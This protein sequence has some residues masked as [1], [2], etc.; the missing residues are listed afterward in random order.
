MRLKKAFP[1][2]RKRFKT[3]WQI[4]TRLRLWSSVSFFRTHLTETLWK[5][6]WFVMCRT[7]TDIQMLCHFVNSRPSGYP[8]SRCG[9]VQCFLLLWTC[10][11]VQ[12][13]HHQ[14]HLCDRFWTWS[15]NHTHSAVVKHCFH[16][17]LKVC[18]GFLPLVHLQ[19]TKN[20]IAALC[21]SLVQTDSA[22]VMLT[23]L[24]WHNYWLLKVETASQWRRQFVL[25]HASTISNVVNTTQFLTRRALGGMHTSAT[26]CLIHGNILG[27]QHIFEISYCTVLYCFWPYGWWRITL[28]N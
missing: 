10:C 28:R 20:R 27:I 11:G 18:D 4:V 1:S 16:I 13:I 19:P 21:S 12:I 14:W 26:Q 5:L 22:A 3:L 25:V 2:W 8:E 24:Q 23:P 7:M 17:V 15:S 6:S 9:L